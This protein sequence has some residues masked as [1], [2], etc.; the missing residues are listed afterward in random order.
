MMPEYLRQRG[1]ELGQIPETGLLNT[2]CQGH[3]DKDF[4]EI[5]PEVEAVL[6]GAESPE[7]CAQSPWG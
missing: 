2:V 6:A 7:E 5:A 1:K 4:I 3:I